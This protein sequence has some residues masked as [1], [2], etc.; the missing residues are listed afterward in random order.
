MELIN[1]SIHD[2]KATSLSRIN[3]VLTILSEVNVSEPGNLN[4]RYDLFRT[5]LMECRPFMP[6]KDYKDARL[7]MSKLLEEINKYHNKQ[8]SN[9]IVIADEF[10]SEMRNFCTKHVKIGG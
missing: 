10:E 7:I 2:I 9:F 4:K 1:T 5:L 8:K 6:E 3:I